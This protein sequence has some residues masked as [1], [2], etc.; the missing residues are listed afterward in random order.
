MSGRKGKSRYW[1]PQAE[2]GTEDGCAW[3]GCEDKGLYRAPRSRQ[4]LTEYAWFCL[5][6]IRQYNAAWNYFS[7]MTDEQVEADVR[8]D[9]VWQRPTWPLGGGK[10]RFDSSRVHDG[11][12]I[13]NDPP[14]GA[15]AGYARTPEEQALVVF[16]LSPPVDADAVK[17][18]YKALVKRHHPDANG[19]DKAAEEKFKQISDAYRTIMASFGS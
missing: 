2:A 10:Y 3:A 18:R 15:G 6:H 1:V 13:F 8:W 11:F 4:V 14:S 9:T 19:G 5:D 17:T 12:G 16:D 7:G